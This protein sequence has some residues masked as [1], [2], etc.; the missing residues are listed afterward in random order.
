MCM[1]ILTFPLFP[2]SCAEIPASLIPDN[3]Y[4]AH[5]KTRL[6]HHLLQDVLHGTR[7]QIFAPNGQATAAAAAA[8]GTG[9]RY[10]DFFAALSSFAIDLAILSFL[11]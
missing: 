3:I 10:F 11:V 9:K 5:L 1:P 7:M 2:G 4:K 6:Y 8:K